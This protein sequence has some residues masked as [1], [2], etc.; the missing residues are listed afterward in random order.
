MNHLIKVILPYIIIAVVSFLFELAFG[1]YDDSILYNLIEGFV[2]VFLIILGMFSVPL[3]YKKTY[4][5]GSFLFF[6]LVCIFESTYSYLFATYFS[7][8][9]IFVILDTNISE[10]KEFF[11]FYL[12]TTL[13]VYMTSYGFLVFF[14]TKDLINKTI[15]PANLP[16]YRNQLFTF[17]AIIFLVGFIKFS[18]LIVY[19]LPYL[20]VKSTFLYLEDSELLNDNLSDGTG[21]FHNVTLTDPK[22][23]EVHVIVVGESTTKSHMGL[24]GYYRKTTPMLEEIKD[25]LLIYED[26][27]APSTYTIHSLTKA[28]TAGNYE[29]PEKTKEGSIIQLLN[30]SGYRTY[31]ISNQQP[32]GMMSSQI[33]RIGKA[34][35]KKVFIN[36]AHT[37]SI[38]P[39]DGHL[40]DRMLEVFN[41]G[42]NKKVIF[43]HLL[44]THFDYKKRFPK[45]FEYFKDSPETKYNSR[46]VHN[47]INS[48]DNAV[49]YND[50]LL[51]TIIEEVRKKDVKAS[52]LYFSDH[53]EELY[54][55]LFFAGH[56]VDNN[57][58]KSMYEIPFILWRSQKYKEEKTISFYPERKYMIDDLFHSVSQLMKIE[59]DEVDV[60]RSIFSDSYKKRKRII[61]EGNESM[62]YDKVFNQ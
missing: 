37:S 51:R 16:N 15:Y 40:V 54:E 56:A 6:S 39:Y 53:G 3:K 8:S 31:W 59:A 11:I 10:S 1:K 9:A 27:I 35:Y 30:Q 38:T 23:K 17:G 25:E 21:N 33:T 5:V 20:I 57:T 62:D 18:N 14:L 52:V 41:D 7:P 43:L 19:N 60:S 29:E 13:V 34:A 44:G 46:K 28:L 4:L 55:D 26:V 24:Y 32:I 61:K 48:Y 50:Y 42:T 2:F 22:Q 36:T 47:Q 49:R 58:T 12:D 45:E